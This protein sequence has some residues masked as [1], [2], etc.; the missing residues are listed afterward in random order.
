MRAIDRCWCDFSTGSFFEPFNVSRWEYLSVQ[1]L[2]KELLNKEE[3]K[4]SSHNETD[5]PSLTTNETT[6]TS[7][8]DAQVTASKPKFWWLRSFSSKT[9]SPVEP[10]PA[11]TSSTTEQEDNTVDDQSS[12]PIHISPPESSHALPFLQKEYDLR[13]NNLGMIID[14]GWS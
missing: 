13:Q 10:S 3:Q 7:S 11:E 6:E 9:P 2:S 5:H 8:H 1:R 12:S 4:E 14:L